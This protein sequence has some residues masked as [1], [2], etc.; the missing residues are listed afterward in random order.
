[1]FKKNRSKKYIVRCLA[2]HYI[3]EGKSYKEISRI[4]KYSKQTIGEWV[5]MYNEGGVDKML[6]IRG[7]SGRKARI[8]NDKKE[9][10]NGF[11]MELQKDRDGGRIIGEDIV[12]MIN[13]KYNESYSVSGVY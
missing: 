6:S 4:I 11:V 1:M 8:K 9:E 10:F 12:S 7:G 2:C 3:Q 13:D 5:K